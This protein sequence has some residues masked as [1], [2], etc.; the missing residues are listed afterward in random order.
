MTQTGPTRV[1]DPHEDYYGEG[2]HQRPRTGLVI[3]TAL[4]TSVATIS[5]LHVLSRGGALARASETQVPELVGLPLARARA[6]ADLA[7]LNLQ[8]MGSVSDPLVAK[9]AVARQIPLAGTS[10]AVGTNVAATLSIGPTSVTVPALKG[11]SLAVAG[12][13]LGEA[14]LKVGS[15]SSQPQEG[16][17]AG[18]VVSTAPSGGTQVPPGSSVDLVVVGELSSGGAAPPKIPAPPALR[19]RPSVAVAPGTPGSVTVPKATGM[20]LQFATGR[21]SSSGLSVGRVSYENDEDHIEGYVLRQSPAPG[22]P[23]PRGTTV[24]L[25]INRTE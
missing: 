6:A 2:G 18:N 7:K 19:P 23:V 11:L 9:G 17:A 10:V 24:D 8:V 13:R 1:H 16:A 3:L 22:T 15:T 21:L 20:R 14:G 12:N 5:A 4:I 25:V